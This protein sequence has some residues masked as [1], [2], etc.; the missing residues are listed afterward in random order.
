MNFSLLLTVFLL[1]VAKVKLENL[2]VGHA[3][4]RLLVCLFILTSGANALFGIG[5]SKT[6]TSKSPT[7]AISSPQKPKTSVFNKFKKAVTPIKKAPPSKTTSPSQNTAKPKSGFLSSLK[8]TVTPAKKPTSSPTNS[9]QSSPP[10]KTGLL[11]SI[12]KVV[13]PAKKPTSSPTNSPQSS[14]P[15]KTG[16]FSKLKNVVAS[17]KSSATPTEDEVGV[18]EGATAQPKTGIFSKIKNVVASKKTPS[19][20]TE[21]GEGLEG[22]LEQDETS[23]SKQGLLSKIKGAVASSQNADGTTKSGVLTRLAKGSMNLATSTQCTAARCTDP[24]FMTPENAKSCLTTVGRARTNINCSKSFYNKFCQ[25]SELGEYEESCQIANEAIQQGASGLGQVTNIASKVNTLVNCTATY[26]STPNLKRNDLYKC[27]GTPKLVK[28]NQACS[29]TYY[30]AHCQES[31]SESPS[32]AE[33]FCSII[34]DHNG[35][36]TEVPPALNEDLSD[37]AS[38][39]GAN[40]A[41]D[42]EGPMDTSEM[43][44]EEAEESQSEISLPSSAQK[45]SKSAGIKLSTVPNL[46]LNDAGEAEEADPQTAGSLSENA[47]EAAEASPP[48]ADSPADNPAADDSTTDQST[49]SSTETAEEG[50][51]ASPPVDDASSDNP[52]ADDSTTPQSTPSSTEAPDEAA[53]AL[54]PA[55]EASSDNIAAN[56]STIDSSPSSYPTK[57][58]DKKNE[59]S[60][61]SSTKPASFTQSTKR[62]EKSNC[63][64]AITYRVLSD[65]NNIPY[66]QR[67]GRI[68]ATPMSDDDDEDDS[69]Y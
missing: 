29:D 40:S 22:G 21:D 51:E 35:E 17:K 5:G 45:G 38:I 68:T 28:L 30:A 33:E 4:I 67:T 8:K 15:Q 37:E 41:T 12:K 53:E 42:S 58:T 52:A 14:P 50:A 46:S 9:P 32:H 19:T 16:I 62:R 20:P 65:S 55:D 24:K 56:D 6:T 1:Q 26:C 18:E 48:S 36:A 7:H 10:Q 64:G 13:T 23:P 31:G 39:E 3:M 44:S 66:S 60:S 63:Q 2:R 47:D 27:I 25:E 61:L 57:E 59:I 54:P 49:P 34:A 11:S 43:G 69:Y